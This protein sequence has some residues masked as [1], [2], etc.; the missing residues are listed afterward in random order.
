MRTGAST[1]PNGKTRIIKL[2]IMRK[3]GMQRISE[4][5]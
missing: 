5:G 3:N 2:G 4:N 1:V